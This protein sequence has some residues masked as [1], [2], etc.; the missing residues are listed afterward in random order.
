MASFRTVSASS[1]SLYKVSGSKHIG[2]SFRVHSEKEAKQIIQNLWEEHPQ[3]THICFAYVLTVYEKIERSSDDGE[4]GGTAG[5]P[6]LNQIKSAKLTEV[7]VAVIRY[8][9]GTKLGVSGLIDAYKNAAKLALE[10]SG[11]EECEVEVQYALSVSHEETPA[12]MNA[13][14]RLSFRKL[15]TRVEMD[16]TIE[17]AIK[18]EV[19][20]QLLSVLKDLRLN[21]L[22]AENLAKHLS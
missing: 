20:T 12:L 7:L 5:K 17:I 16:F 6:I 21:S 4:P 14:N 22:K 3:A 2:R 19:E 11:V 10:S 1:E 13:L 18:E 15:N 8:Y 9:G